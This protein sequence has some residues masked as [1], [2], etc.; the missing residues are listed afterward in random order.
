MLNNI[1]FLYFVFFATII[2]LF[3][4][5]YNKDYQS[6]F[7]F[8]CMVLIVYI[9]NNNMIIVLLSSLIFV[10]LLIFLNKMNNK[11]GLKNEDDKEGLE[12]DPLLETKKTEKAD[13]PTTIDTI[14]TLDKIVK[15]ID[16]ENSKEKN[17]VDDVNES[18]DLKKKIDKVDKVCTNSELVYN[19]IN[20]L[21]TKINELTKIIQ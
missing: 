9:F 2:N 21:N 19:K 15:G 10:N 12:N 5:M 6:V 16:A 17:I 1:Y 18:T 7:L 8:S 11:E 20:E 4:F 13:T 3:G 14:T